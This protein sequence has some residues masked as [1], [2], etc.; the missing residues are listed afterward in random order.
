MMMTTCWSFWMPRGDEA[1]SGHGPAC[2][3]AAAIAAAAS[4]AAAPRRRMR[5]LRAR[6]GGAAGPGAVDLAGDGASAGVAGGGARLGSRWFIVL[7][8][9]PSGRGCKMRSLFEKPSA[10][11]KPAQASGDLEENTLFVEGCERWRS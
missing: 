1:R 6:A 4:S 2:P 11:W 5:G 8:L 7:L 9:P 3:L 10:P